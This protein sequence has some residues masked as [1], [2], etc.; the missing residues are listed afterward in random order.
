MTP[1]SPPTGPSL[2]AIE[3]GLA[4]I[5]VAAGL[6][7]PRAGSPVFRVCEKSLGRLARRRAL[8]VFIIGAAAGVLRLAILPL[9]PIPRPYVS[10]EFSYLLAAETFASGR[11][12]NP[13]HPMWT[14]FES[15]HIIFKP[16]YMSMYFPAQGLL[17]A[18]GKVFLGYPWFGVWIS[19]ALMCAA[20]CWMLQGWLP[21]GWA[22]L[23]G[24]LAVVRIGLFSYWI[25][26]YWG[27]ALPALAGALVLGALPRLQRDFRARDFF[28][29]S[30]GSAIFAASRPYEGLLVCLPALGM[31]FWSLSRRPRPQPAIL[32]RRTV[33]GLALLTLTFGFLGYYNY[34]VFGNAFTPPYK[35]N[36]ETYASAPHFVFQ[37][38]RSEP[39]YHHKVMRDF[40]TGLELRWFQDMQTPIG[41]LKKTARKTGTAILFYFGTLLLVPLVMLPRVIGD[42]RTRYLVVAGGIFA[43]GLMVETWFI[44]HYAAAFTAGIYVIL[45]Q[46]MRHLRACRPRGRSVG[47]FFVRTTPLVC[48]TLVVLRLCAGPLHINLPGAK[49]LNPYG[50]VPAGLRRAAVETQLNNSSGPQLAIVRYSPDH[51]TYEEW[52][53]NAANIDGSKL[54]WARDMD[55]ASN[56]RLLQYYRGRTTW[57]VEPDCNPPR[58]SPFTLVQE[59]SAAPA[60]ESN[61]Y[62]R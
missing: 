37:S 56:R 3:L 57:L 29:L 18:T 34:R 50:S 61:E 4:L 53:Y 11:L 26:S 54:I 16:T 13:P 9:N 59:S 40:Y 43:A 12:T 15:F 19:T 45:L 7:W 38:A 42:Q 33:P 25:D 39:V 6:C 31:L 1:A 21:A 24:F 2:L 35:V 36:R 5:I 30:L 47:F 58:I 51:D 62:S 20:I 10:D 32:F 27:G 44:P 49:S 48:L 41:F 60:H 17:L 8:C 14:H 55:A 23:G 52:V 22:L 28:W 46:C